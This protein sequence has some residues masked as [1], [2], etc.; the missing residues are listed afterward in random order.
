MSGGPA[1]AFAAMLAL[2]ASISCPA[3]AAPPPPRALEAIA[4][5]NR[6]ARD[7]DYVN[8]RAAMVDDFRWSFGGDASAAQALEEWKKRPGSLRRL[9]KVTQGKCVLHSDGAVECPANAGVSFRAGFTVRD[10]Q[11][12]L[13]YFIAGD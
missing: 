13:A 5:V 2:V 8:L 10:G 4:K 7:N 12:K 9:V 6:A 3:A 11:W 1:L